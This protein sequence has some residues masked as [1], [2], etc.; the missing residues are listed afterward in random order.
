MMQTTVKFVCVFIQII[1][2]ASIIHSIIRQDGIIK[3]L[4]V[5]IERN[6]AYLT[7]DGRE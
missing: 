6:E 1:A 4:D 5:V 7:S 3:R 2:L